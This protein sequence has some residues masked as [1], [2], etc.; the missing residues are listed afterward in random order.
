MS[1]RTHAETNDMQSARTT[2]RVWGG[3]PNKYLTGGQM[4]EKRN[5]VHWSILALRNCR[6]AVHLLLPL[7]QKIATSFFI[8]G[9]RIAL[10][11]YCHFFGKSITSFFHK[12]L[13]AGI[14]PLT[15][16]KPQKSR[17]DGLSGKNFSGGSV[18]PDNKA[19]RKLR[20]AR[21]LKKRQPFFGFTI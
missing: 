14:L 21:C 12:R 5:L 10:T 17:M 11:C 16:Y 3:N 20:F 18:F 9:C 4:S 2:R 1:F 6:T 7:F 15:P 19:F 13:R 8:K